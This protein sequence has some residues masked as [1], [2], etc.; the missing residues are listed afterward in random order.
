MLVVQAGEKG[1]KT[2]ARGWQAVVRV[3]KCPELL[4]LPSASPPLNLGLD[5]SP[6]EVLGLST[7]ISNRRLVVIAR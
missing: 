2:V 7:Q 1:F 6:V 3:Q 4:P 5:S